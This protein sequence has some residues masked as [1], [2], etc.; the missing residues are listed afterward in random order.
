MKLVL[1]SSLFKI[2]LNFILFCRKYKFFIYVLIL[3]YIYYKKNKLKKFIIKK[4]K[5][6]NYVQ[7]KKKEAVH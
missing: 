5:N 6:T 2:P 1:F 4:I 7:H 3:N